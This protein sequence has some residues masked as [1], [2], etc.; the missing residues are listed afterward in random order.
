[1]KTRRNTIG[2]AFACCLGAFGAGSANA[3]APL[4]D[5]LYLLPA[6]ASLR[7]VI[8]GGGIFGLVG[9]Y[10]LKEKRRVRR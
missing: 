3:Q 2:M 8:H 4:Q 7:G 5:V 10:V 6:P 1:M 9:R